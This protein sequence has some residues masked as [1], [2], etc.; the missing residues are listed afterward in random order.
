MLSKFIHSVYTN[1]VVDDDFPDPRIIEVE[2]HGFFAYATH[3]EFSPTLNNIL[4]RHS[5]N[6]VN[7]SKAQG[8][9]QA[10]PVWAMQSHKF[11]CP[12]IA[13][14]GNTFRLYYAAEPDTKDGMCLAL[15]TSD[16]TT[17]F[18]DIGVPLLQNINSTFKLIDPCFFIDP[19]SNK[20]LLFYGSAH[21]PIRVAELAEDGKTFITNPIEVLLPE[22]TT[23]HKL[24][25]GAFV[26]YNERWKRYFL[27]VSGDNT[28]VS[29][30]YAVSVFWSENPLKPFQ[31]IPGNS[32]VLHANEFWDA[33]GHCCVIKDAN[34]T[35]WIVYHAVDA[36]D[37]FIPGTDRFLRK[38]CI[39]EV[40]YSDD[41]WPYI[42]N[43]SPS[44]EI[45]N[46]PTVKT[47]K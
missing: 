37:P 25:E 2:G 12:H 5:P 16:T 6:M 13:Q 31:K 38:M 22:T 11:W 35:E 46:G 10:L 32:V 14:V 1:P 29:N 18:C 7:W 9:L 15:A 19:I 28:W 21:E 8:A 23:Y 34:Y 36:K 27:W 39:D 4:V 47:F 30:A 44:F 43:S 26:T 45:Q 40:L 42:K 17:G 24:L 3:D 20:H 41:G 33:P